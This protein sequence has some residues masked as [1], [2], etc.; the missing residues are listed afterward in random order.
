M[1]EAEQDLRLAAWAGDLATLKRLVEEG[2]D[3][4]AK[5]DRGWTALMNAAL[6]GKLDCLELLI[7][8]GAK[9]DATRS[10]GTALM[11]AAGSG[12]LDC[13]KLLIAKGA[14]LEAT[15]IEGG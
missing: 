1:A 9:L 2:V 6:Q 4:E 12:K 11:V 14:N 7:A 13:L 8:K 15:S 5:D 10:S 3:L